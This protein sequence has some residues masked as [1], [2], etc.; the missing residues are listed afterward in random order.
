M[1]SF[2]NLVAANPKYWFGANLSSKFLFLFRWNIRRH[3]DAS[4]NR[5][6]IG[7][8]RFA[9]SVWFESRHHNGRRLSPGGATEPRLENEPELG[10]KNA[11][12]YEINRRI[13]NFQHVADLDE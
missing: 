12:D 10:T 5:H 4:A 7:D 3:G 8:A 11:I 13:E 2:L 1:C 9:A 6:V